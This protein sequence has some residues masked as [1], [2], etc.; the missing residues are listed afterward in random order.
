MPF[1]LLPFVSNAF[2]DVPYSHRAPHSCRDGRSRTL[3]RQVSQPSRDYRELYCAHTD[4]ARSSAVAIVPLVMELIA[5]K[6][7]VDVGCGLGPWLATFA[8]HGV[9]DFL[10]LDGEW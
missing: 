3:R 8:R 6:S 1:R 2:A 7:V 10:G 9:S 5:P 4:M